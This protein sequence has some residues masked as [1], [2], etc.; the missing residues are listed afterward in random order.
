MDFK[1]KE[2]IL[3]FS[4]YDTGKTVDLMIA[5]KIWEMQ[6]VPTMQNW[7]PSKTSF[8][9]KFDLV[10]GKSKDLIDGSPFQQLF[11]GR[12]HLENRVEPDNALSAGYLLMF[13]YRSTEN[14]WRTKENVLRYLSVT[15]DVRITFS[16][17][18]EGVVCRYSDADSGRA[19]LLPISI[20]ETMFTWCGAWN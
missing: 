2:R 13:M 8:L 15:V 4:V 7:K 20:T 3:G 16:T 18:Y 6:K 12:L 9:M 11:G 14:L 10:T 5:P 1:L 19:L 17:D